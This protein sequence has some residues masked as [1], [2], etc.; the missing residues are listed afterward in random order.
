MVEV[1]FCFVFSFFLFFL[2]SQSSQKTNIV[3]VLCCTK[4]KH[5]NRISNQNDKLQHFQLFS[6]F[7]FVELDSKSASKEW[8][9][10]SKTIKTLQL[11]A[12]QKQ[13]R[14]FF[15]TLKTN[16][17]SEWY[18]FFDSSTQQ[19]T[20]THVHHLL[21]QICFS[22]IPKDMAVFEGAS[23]AVLKQGCECTKHQICSSG[24]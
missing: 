13:N 16:W 11:R 4:K 6:R 10:F 15:M 3:L 5:K 9:I 8:T 7:W 17:K 23:I 14:S 21:L 19:Q 20:L 1:L 18:F 12:K 22:Q 24:I 2:C